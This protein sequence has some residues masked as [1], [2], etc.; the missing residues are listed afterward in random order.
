MT[1]RLKIYLSEGVL[2]VEGSESFVKAIY[3][4]FKAHFVGE[5]AVEDLFKPIKRKR[6]KTT[7]PSAPKAK[8][9]PPA[10]PALQVKPPAVPPQ[11]TVIVEPEPEPPPPKPATKPPA[12]KPSYTFLEDLNLSADKERPS[13]V[14]FMDAKFPITNEE[15]NLVFV[16]YLQNILKI[17][18]ITIDHIYTCY[19]AAKIR[20]PI[21]IEK[22]LH[23]A[24]NWIS[25]SKTGRLTVKAAGKRYLEQQ[26]PKK[27]KN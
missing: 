6:S 8:V 27:I 3:N 15:R 7:K 14:E 13:L 9:S 2:E 10:E 11:E 25:I 26:L 4:D 23:M 19:K 20:V 12:P 24:A 22:S 18:P 5:D 16:H 21:N 1:T 17:K